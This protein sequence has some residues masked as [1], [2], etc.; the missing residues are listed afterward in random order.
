[1]KNIKLILL[2][3][4]VFS[5]GA[6]SD[7]LETDILTKKTEGNFYAT[8]EDA[9][10]ALTG[11]YDAMQLLYSYGENLVGLPVATS[12]MSDVCFGGT[13]AGDGNNYPMMDEFDMNVAPASVNMFESNWQN[14]YKGIK[15]VNTLIMR[16]EQ[17]EWGNDSDLKNE[18]EGEA[19]FLRAFF[20]FDMVRMWERVPLLTE[21]T[22]EL[23]PQAKPDEVYKLIA[24]DLLVAIEKCHTKTYD[25]IADAEFGHASKWAAEALMTRVFLY[26]TGYYGANDLLGLVTKQQALD[27]VEDVIANSGHGLVDDYYSLWPAAAQYKAVQDGG[28]INDANY[29]GETNKEVVFAIKY[30][31]TSNYDGNLDGNHWMIMNGIRGEAVPKYGYGYGW[32]GCTVVPEFYAS[33]DENDDR[34]DASI[35]AV[36]E[37]S[38]DYSEKKD[39]KEYT[40]YFTKKYTPLCNEDGEH[41][42]VAFGGA[43][44]MIGQYQDYFSIRYA[45]VLLM[46]AELGSSSALDYLNQVHTRAGLD[47][48]NE[49]SKDIIYEERRNEFAFEGVWY[50]DLLRYDGTLDY[51]ANAVS[52]N[53]TVQTAGVEQNKVIDGNNLKKV[54]GLFQIPYNQITL[55]NGTYTQNPGWD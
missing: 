2:L 40:G 35:M 28:T 19:H 27:Y 52:Y 17:V 44:F 45:D 48:L 50:W 10:Q 32:G 46:A 8:P 55:S 38:I 29:A 53:G 24:E 37:E 5:L 14:Y 4:S 23:V 21:P 1:M 41:T 39:V 34:R 12:V 30:T 15:R 22:D 6:C 54:R 33:F 13:G 16:L 51:A 36:E 7:F 26:Y 3:F 42:T 25:E 18:I 9:Q 43:D 47:P 20:Y 31:Y 11:C 49:V